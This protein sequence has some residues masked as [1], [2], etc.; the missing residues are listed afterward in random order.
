MKLFDSGDE[1]SCVG[2]ATQPPPIDA[3]LSHYTSC[4]GVIG[5]LYSVE[6]SGRYWHVRNHQKST[7]VYL[8]IYLI[9][10][11]F[12]DKMPPKR[13]RDCKRRNGQMIKY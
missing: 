10:L 4:R 13:L 8:L 11:P 1:V 2:I 3:L 6:I 9:S 5:P 7:I 12:Y